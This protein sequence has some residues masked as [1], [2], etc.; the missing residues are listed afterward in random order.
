MPVGYSENLHFKEGGTINVR[1]ENLKNYLSDILDSLI[2]CGVKRFCFLAPHLGNVPIITQLAIHLHTNTPARQ[3][4]R[5]SCISAPNTVG[6]Q[7]G[8]T[9]SS[10]RLYA[11]LRYSLKLS[12]GNG[13]MCF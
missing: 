9:A 7:A 6:H 4:H 5:H 11:I 12:S 8:K 10:V 1:P 13:L 3:E 2:E